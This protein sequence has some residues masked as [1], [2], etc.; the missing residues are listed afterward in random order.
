MK[1]EVIQAHVQNNL[2]SRKITLLTYAYFAEYA[3]K[4]YIEYYKNRNTSVFVTMLDA[5]KAFDRVNF[6]LLFQKL[7]SRNVPF[8]IFRI[9][10]M[11][12]TRQNM[13]IRWSNA[14]SPS[15]TDSNGV[16][17]GDI[18]SPILFNVYVDG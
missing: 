10:A 5:S 2:A 9:L 6:W 7:L 3:L 15:F 16:K 8:F 17:Q 14:I 11:W 13:C 18:I 12:Y 4:E 1:C